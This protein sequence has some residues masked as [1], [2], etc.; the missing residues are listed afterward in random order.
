MMTPELDTRQ[1]RP[2]GNV[3]SGYVTVLHRPRQL[4]VVRTKLSTIR[5]SAFVAMFLALISVGNFAC[6]GESVSIE[7]VVPLDFIGSA[8]GDRAVALLGDELFVGDNLDDLVGSNQ[9]SVTVYRRVSGGW[10]ETQTLL[11]DPTILGQKFG[12][13]VTADRDPESGE[14]WLVVG[15]PAWLDTTT[16]GRVYFFRENEKGQWEEQQTIVAPGDF[17]EDDWFGWDVDVNVA[18][19]Q[20]DLTDEPLWVTVVGAPRHKL[21]LLPNQ[22]GAL[23]ISN[24]N[25]KGLWTPAEPP[26]AIEQAASLFS[27][28][29]WSVAVA[30]DVA[31]A[32]APAWDPQQ[33]SQDFEPVPTRYGAVNLFS[34]GA[35]LQWRGNTRTE[36]PDVLRADGDRY[37]ESVAVAQQTIDNGYEYA[38]GSPGTGQFAEG[39]AY[40]ANAAGAGLDNVIRVEREAPML[41]D[42]FGHSVSIDEDPEAGDNRIFISSLSEGGGERGSVLEYRRPLIT[43]PWTLVNQIKLSDTAPGQAGQ[44]GSVGFD[45][46]ARNGQVALSSSPALGGAART[47]YVTESPI[48]VGNFEVL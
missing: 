47:V 21:E 42:R 30:G 1:R 46:A 23:L 28:L 29:G 45:L 40:I 31:I 41:G 34:R 33:D 4:S 32:G 13:S 12:Q 19:P 7:R 9:G 16:R 3:S 18:V 11:P 44:T 5:V 20:S 22:S 35:Q 43:D 36:N 25:A 48:F 27:E 6:A 38:V 15:A 14:A 10:Q 8:N 17:N 26:I 37:G 24:L 39:V 2:L